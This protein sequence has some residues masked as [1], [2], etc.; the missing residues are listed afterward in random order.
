MLP[1]ALIIFLK[2]M[3]IKQRRHCKLVGIT[4]LKINIILYADKRA[5]QPVPRLRGGGAAE[6]PYLQ[7]P[8]CRH[9]EQHSGN[10]EGGLSTLCAGRILAGFLVVVSERRK[11]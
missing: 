2:I 3:V 6:A 5:G 11:T 9:R 10:G 1:N 4:Y 8:G 7:E